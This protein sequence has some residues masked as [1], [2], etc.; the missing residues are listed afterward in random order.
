[1]PT[2]T[3]RRNRNKIYSKLK[4]GTSLLKRSGK[5]NNNHSVG[6]LF[7]LY[8]IY[9][10]TQYISTY[11]HPGD[12]PESPFIRCL[13]ISVRK[14][15]TFRNWVKTQEYKDCSRLP[16]NT[17]AKTM[18]DYLY[19]NHTWMDFFNFTTEQWLTFWIQNI[20]G[21][22]EKHFGWNE[23]DFLNR[24]SNQQW[25]IEHGAENKEPPPISNEE[26]LYQSWMK[27]PEQEWNALSE[28]GITPENSYGI[29]MV[30]KGYLKKP[31]KIFYTV[32]MKAIPGCTVSET[33]P[34]PNYYFSDSE[35]QRE[36]L[37]NRKPLKLP[38]S[39]DPLR[40]KLKEKYPMLSIEYT[41]RKI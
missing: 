12:P 39:L 35:D 6:E 13:E 40:E 28:F 21:L 27:N 5:Y 37:K 18:M 38:P 22:V 10:P 8:A 36:Y 9:T 14:D 41:V 29:A 32:L 34:Y 1:M 20:P 3:Q 23:Q 30:C 26:K 15:T 24:S 2:R 7:D 17:W 16:L 25:L 33:N 4:F 31:S 19:Y 11:R